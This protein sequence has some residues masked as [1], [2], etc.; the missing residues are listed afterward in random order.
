MTTEGI[1]SAFGI[2]V[3]QFYKWRQVQNDGTVVLVPPGEESP[4]AV[5]E[6]KTGSRRKKSYRIVQDLRGG[7]TG[8]DAPYAGTEPTSDPS[9]ALRDTERVAEPT[10]AQDASALDHGYL[11]QR[12]EQLSRENAALEE[13][14]SALA[15][16][17]AELSAQVAQHEEDHS[18]L[19][20]TLDHARERHSGDMKEIALRIAELTE[21]GQ[22]MQLRV[23][24]LE[25]LEDEIPR[26]Q[27]AVDEREKEADGLHR[28]VEQIQTAL[29]VASVEEVEEFRQRI[30]DMTSLRAIWR[31]RRWLQ[32]KA[33]RFATVRSS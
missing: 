16:R 32:T 24:E 18:A 31:N 17:D 26:L 2:G 4:I 22:E 23:I 5:I 21:R 7:P 11:L 30:K 13:R 29:G 33:R 3:R 9:S 6:T 19:H 10:S 27:A 15:Y 12:I 20:R 28:N 25:P 1:A 14:N 8:A